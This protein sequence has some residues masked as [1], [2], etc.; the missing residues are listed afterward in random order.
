MDRMLQPSPSD[1]A[2]PFPETASKEF[3]EKL[4]SEVYAAYN[5]YK[6]AWRSYHDRLWKCYEDFSFVSGRRVSKLFSN[7]QLP[8]IYTDVRLLEG[9]ITDAI[10]ATNPLIHVRPEGQLAPEDMGDIAAME[11]RAGIL[12]DVLNNL[13]DNNGGRLTDM[14]CIL[15]GLIFGPMVAKTGWEVDFDSDGI[16]YRVR[17]EY[18]ISLRIAPY[19]F[20]LDPRSRDVQESVRTYETITISKDDLAARVKQG[21]FDAQAAAAVSFQAST[22]TVAAEFRQKMHALRGTQDALAYNASTDIIE[23]MMRID[24]DGNGQATMHT[25]WF[26]PMSGRLLGFRPCTAIGGDKRPIVLGYLFPATGDNPLGIGVVEVLRGMARAKSSLANQALDNASVSAN[27][28]T[29]VNNNAF[30]NESEL[31][32]STPGGLIHADDITPGGV[33]IFQAKAVTNELL[34]LSGYL[35]SEMQSA[36]SITDIAMAMK[37]PSTAY[38]TGLISA[39]SQA[40]FDILATFARESFF[41]PMYNQLLTLTQKFLDM[42]VPAKV[43]VMGSPEP[44]WVDRRA[45]Q[46]NFRAECNDLRVAGKRKADAQILMNMFSLMTQSGAQ[47]D[48]SDW[49]R[50]ILSKNDTPQS[51]IDRLVPSGVSIVP[52]QAT[53]GV[54][55]QPNPNEYGMPE[56]NPD[57]SRMQIRPGPG[58]DVPQGNAM[59]ALMG[60]QA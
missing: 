38:A 40:N 47:F 17:R 18:P 41:T 25:I 60:G 1:Q 51:D 15:D 16:G 43:D 11:I 49:V 46:G 56:F 10:L 13:H 50:Y 26:D 57:A 2:T 55:G 33:G 4:Q 6:S 12:K 9:R 28:R 29:L 31:K 34:A 22:L 42:Q 5:E 19:A 44:I 27:A 59:P 23:C 39:Q 48:L 37:A 30:V 14:L 24:P 36:S 58:G 21:K 54:Q 52:Q 20:M 3:I 7:L 35:D 32:N 8:T 53:G 45:L